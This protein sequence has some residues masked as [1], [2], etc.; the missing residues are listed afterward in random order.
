M[1]L[2]ITLSQNSRN[3]HVTSCFMSVSHLLVHS[4]SLV[5]E[6]VLLLTV[7][8]PH[9]AQGLPCH[10]GSVKISRVTEGAIQTG[11]QGQ[12]LFAHNSEFCQTQEG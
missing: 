9:S 7:R 3:T 8:S 4:V 5:V 6:D 1:T 12:G 11:A 10:G 2:H